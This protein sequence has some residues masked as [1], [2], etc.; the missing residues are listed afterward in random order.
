MMDKLCRA[1]SAVVLLLAALYLV[2]TLI[3]AWA[4]VFVDGELVHWPLREG[5]TYA[6]LAVKGFAGAM[7]CIAGAAVLN[8]M[9]TWAACWSTKWR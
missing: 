2:G 6:A 5:E 4:A 3:T 7:F 8:A 1:L 9:P